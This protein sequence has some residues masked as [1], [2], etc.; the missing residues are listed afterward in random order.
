VA[1]SVFGYPL[2]GC[3][4]ACFCHFSTLRPVEED[5]DRKVAGEFL[6]A[7]DHARWHEENVSHPKAMPLVAV[8]KPA[9]A[10]GHYVH[11]VAGVGGLGIVLARGIELDG[12]RA[13]AEQLHKP[14]TPWPW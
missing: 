12:E 13:M 4:V 6:E 5:P 11:L 14:L 2:R 8:P 7:V 10:L 3:A 9:G 1:L